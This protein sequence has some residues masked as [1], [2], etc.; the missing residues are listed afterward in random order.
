MARFSFAKMHGAGNDFVLIDDRSLAFPCGDGGRVAALA[1]RRTGIG[2]EGVIL[3]QPSVAADFRMRFF[4]PDGTEADLCGNGA[5]CVAAFARDIGAVGADK[6]LFETRAGMVAAEIEEPTR[7]RV[8]VPAPRLPSKDFCIAGVP[9]RI[10]PVGDVSRADVEGEGRRIRFSAEFAP[11][12]TNVDF[13]EYSPPGRLSI[14]TYERGVEAESGACGTGAV[15]ASVVGVAGYGLK[16][17]VEV[18]TLH[19]YL[20]QVDGVFDGQ[21]FSNI[22]LSGPVKR[23]FSGVIDIDGLECGFAGSPR[24]S[25]CP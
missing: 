3:V 5:R 6:M 11:Q 14:R 22:T 2:C 21:N 19:G 13:V 7:V 15:S 18:H 4:N 10:V 1:A 16:F 25:V 20:L 9:H 24:Q 17:P 12:G 23:V 8:S